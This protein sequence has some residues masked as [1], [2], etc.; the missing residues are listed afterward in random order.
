MTKDTQISTL[1]IIDH[2]HSGVKVPRH[3]I[4]GG[5]LGLILQF[6]SRIWVFQ[7]L[8]YG[9]LVRDIINSIVIEGGTVI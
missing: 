8:L 9:L 2:C 1:P 5:D 7:S 6:K 3:L 4:G